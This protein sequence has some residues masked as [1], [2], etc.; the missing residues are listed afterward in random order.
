MS[1]MFILKGSEW[2]SKSIIPG[3][4]FATGI[5]HVYK[6]DGQWHY[7]AEKDGEGDY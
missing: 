7:I 2:V 4:P 3:K 5:V 1:T 6:Q